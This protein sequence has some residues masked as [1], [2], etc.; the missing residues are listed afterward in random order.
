MPWM[1]GWA[2]RSALREVSEVTDAAVAAVGE[3]Q[4][5]GVLGVTGGRKVGTLALTGL[6][7]HRRPLRP[8]WCRAAGRRGR[9]AGHS[10]SAQLP[11]ALPSSSA[12]NAE[13]NLVAIEGVAVVEPGAGRR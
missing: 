6:H 5:H 2:K 1:R 9:I 4:H 8:P 12:L 11:A 13:A 3:H 10:W 7:H